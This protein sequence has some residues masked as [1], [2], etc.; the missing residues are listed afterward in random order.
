MK[1]NKIDHLAVLATFSSYG[2]RKTSME[3]LASSVGLSRQGLYKKFKSKTAV[4]EWM[5]STV[6]EEGLTG[7]TETL[8]DETK[9]II[10]RLVLVFDIWTGQFIEISRCST[11]GFNVADHA[12]AAMLENELNES[13]VTTLI[14]DALVKNGTT[15]NATYANDCA[16][17]FY[18]ASRGLYL[19][20]AS[21]QDF[22]LGIRRII[23]TALFQ[24]KD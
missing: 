11:N 10:D 1:S 14:A 16:F 18:T 8:A 4:F 20:A 24:Q 15:S 7:I 6:I 3:A 9:P 21:R 17:L 2:F 5:V 13:S 19:T 23:T 12:A 22:S